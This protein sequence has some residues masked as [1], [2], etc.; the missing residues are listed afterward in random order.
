M[1]SR[2]LALLIMLS[3][4]TLGAQSPAPPIQDNSFLIEEAYNQEQGIVQHIFTFRNHRGSPD[5]EAS[6]TQEWPV[7][8]ITHQLS[9]DLFLI[10]S[11]HETGIGDVRINYRY[12]AIGSGLTRLAMSPRLSVTLPTGDWKKGRGNGA[13]GIETMIPV[14]Y[15]LSPLFT[16]HFDAG[17]ALTP[18]ARN[19]AGDRANIY[20]I[21]LGHSLVLTA[22]PNV[23]FLVETLYNRGQEVTG[24]STTQ[25]TDDLVI[26]PGVRGAINFASGLQIVPGVAIPIGVGPRHGDRGVFVYLSFEHPF[27]PTEGHP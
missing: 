26:S 13:P 3:P 14:S 12:Q 18:R 17:L 7:G 24:K 27:G 25:W 1:A 8:G 5:Y 6:F 11:A 19:T 10:R 4:A 21:T 23:Q 9:Y 15:V 16:T 20:A 2:N 22:H